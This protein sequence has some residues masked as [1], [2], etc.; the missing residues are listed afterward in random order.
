MFTFIEKTFSMSLVLIFAVII[1]DHAVA[2]DHNKPKTNSRFVLVPGF[3]LQKGGI[4]GHATQKFG[5]EFSLNLTTLDKG[6]FSF[7][8]LTYGM[9]NEKNYAE[10]QAGGSGWLL[11]SLVFGIGGVKWNYES[12]LIP[13]AT[14]SLQFLTPIF[15]YVRARSANPESPRYSRSNASKISWGIMF[16]LPVPI[17]L[18]NDDWLQ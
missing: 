4:T 12:K 13:Q 15:L 7:A 6:L 10:I 1:A 18:P 8:G 2:Q 16:K 5:R 17:I 9:D 14:I 3:T 11:A